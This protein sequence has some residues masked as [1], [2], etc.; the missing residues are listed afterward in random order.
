MSKRNNRLSDDELRIIGQSVTTVMLGFD[1][2]LKDFISD[3]VR[4]GLREYTITYYKREVNDFRRWLLFTDRSLMIS[5]VVR[6]DIDE[7][8]DYLQQHKQLKPGT[9][10]AR[11]RALRTLFN[12]LYNTKQID[13]NPMHKY[14]LMKERRGNIETFTIKQIKALLNTP[15][16]NTFTGQRDYTFMLLLLETG[17]RL[18]EATGILAEDI[19]MSEGVVFIRQTKN[20]FHRY[21]PIQSKM[22]EQLRRYLKIRGTC[23]TEHLFVTLDGKPMT[24][25]SLQKV[26]RFHGDN[27]GIKGVRLSAHTFRHTFA[28]LSVIN[29]AGIFE[30]Q[31]ILGHSTM[32]MVRTYVNLFSSEVNQKHKEFSPLKDL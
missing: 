8:I 29:G 14:P 1:D 11:I 12:F 24:R 6:R 15:D 3:C 20:H 19:K 7:Y 17:I 4:R 28:K 32:E 23:E 25:S 26:V 30:L 21:V 31:K 2:A 9:V 13:S 18:N 22:K 16:L 27:A 10:N 5:E